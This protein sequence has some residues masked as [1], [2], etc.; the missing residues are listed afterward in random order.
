[1]GRPRATS[2]C[3]VALMFLWALL[4]MTSIAHA[5]NGAL[6]ARGDS[7]APD[8]ATAS[9]AV[10]E[11]L[12]QSGWRL[13]ERQFS[14]RE[15]DSVAA[16]LRNDK[17][18]SCIVAVLGDRTIE[19]LA[20]VSV[21]PR[22]SPDGSSLTVV[23]ARIV[24]ARENLAY[25]DEQFCERCNQEKLRGTALAVTNKVLSRVYL[26]SNRA[27]L[28]VKSTPTGAKVIVDGA[29]MGVTDLAFNLLPGRHTV[30][31]SL[32]GYRDVHRS[33][34]VADGEAAEVSVILEPEEVVAADAPAAKLP[35]TGDVPRNDEALEQRV[36][37]SWVAPAAVGVGATAAITGIVFMSADATQPRGEIQNEKNVSTRGI[38]L[39]ASGALIASAGVYL[40]RWPPMRERKLRS[41]SSAS[42]IPLPNGFAA[43]IAG[44]F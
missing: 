36:L 26:N 1:M 41:S 43:S 15:V 6:L 39:L 40:W 21:D 23:T 35:S 9:G 19:Q 14:A 2:L 11:A 42:V 16:C 30:K 38:V 32:R 13:S 18:W 31:L 33:V 5:G 10:Q 3:R 12:S 17:P 7:P 34:D 44:R 29:V 37:P 8:R 27:S 28:E 24:V 25:G 20:I 22:R 4:G